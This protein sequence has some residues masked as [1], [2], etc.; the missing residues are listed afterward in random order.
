MN[1][2][3]IV[4]LKQ[5]KKHRLASIKGFK[6]NIYCNPRVFRPALDRNLTLGT[7]KMVTQECLSQEL[8]ES[9]QIPS[10]PVTLDTRRATKGCILNQRILN[11]RSCLQSRKTAGG[12]S[13]WQKILY[14]YVMASRETFC[15]PLFPKI[16]LFLSRFEGKQNCFP[17]N[18]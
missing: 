9:S 3:I 7:L 18:Q 12:L 1:F 8:S 10:V 17:R 4:P 14:S 15:F 13:S 2:L 5:N 16:S 11:K 6:R